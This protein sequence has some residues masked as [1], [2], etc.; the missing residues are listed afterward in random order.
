MSQDRS[1]TGVT[2]HSRHFKRNH[3]APHH[4]VSLSGSMNNC[5]P[6]VLQPPPMSP[7]P[8]NQW[9]QWCLPPG[10]MGRIMP[11]RSVRPSRP[12][13]Q[14]G[15]VVFPRAGPRTWRGSRFERSAQNRFSPMRK[16]PHRFQGGRPKEEPLGNAAEYFKGG[17]LSSDSTNVTV[18]T[19]PLCTNAEKQSITTEVKKRK[20]ISKFYPSKPWNRQDAEKALRVELEAY[21]NQVKTLIIRFPDPD[22][23]WDIIRSYHKSIEKV[24]FLVPSGP[25]YCFIQLSDD[26]DVD[27]VIKE[28]REVDFHNLG[29]IQV[30]KK[31]ERPEGNVDPEAIDPYTLY[32]GN[33]PLTI[34]PSII[35]EK[36]PTAARIDVGYAQKMKF[37]RYAFIRYQ[38]VEESIEAFRSCHNVMFDS[39]NLIVRFRRQGGKDTL[40]VDFGTKLAMREKRKLFQRKTHMEDLKK[41][42]EKKIKKEKVEKED[43][44]YETTLSDIIGNEPASLNDDGDPDSEE[45]EKEVDDDDD[46]DDDDDDDEIDFVESWRAEGDQQN[47]EDD[48]EEEEEDDDDDDDDDE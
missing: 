28:L 36:F 30:E 40:A 15:P 1:Q 11:I 38:T 26:S 42:M 39:R 35:K 32:I 4:G 9:G 34:N 5:H 7:G 24:H 48:E 21:K 23:S 3:Q 8:Q 13:R 10:P 37:T 47:E 44:N 2:S 22:L 17:S 27:Q 14:G 6:P 41:L 19:E 43:G 25:R 46:E 31:C 18:K 33:L 45:E 29:K 16:S 20:S 12:R